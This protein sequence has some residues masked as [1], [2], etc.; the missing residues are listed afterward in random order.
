MQYRDE[1]MALVSCVDTVYD[2]RVAQLA[3]GTVF[4]LVFMSKSISI[5]WYTLPIHAISQTK[6]AWGIEHQSV[7]VLLLVPILLARVQT[8]SMCPNYHPRG[9]GR[10][11]S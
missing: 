10:S 7:C 11:H 1:C 4:P 6:H 9:R 5:F 2:L 3:T 8:M